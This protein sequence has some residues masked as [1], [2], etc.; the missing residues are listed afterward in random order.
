MTTAELTDFEALKGIL[1]YTDDRSVM[2]WCRE[3]NIPV[4]KMGFK[5]YISSHS[6]TQYIDNQLVIFEVPKPELKI[7]RNISKKKD[8][9]QGNIYNEYLAKFDSIKKTKA[10]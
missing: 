6:L 8:H 3:Q 10:A 7:I 2:K 1:G 4:L 5:K 9:D